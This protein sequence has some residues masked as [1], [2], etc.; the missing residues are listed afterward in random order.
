MRSFRLC[1]DPSRFLVLF[2]PL[3]QGHPASDG[4]DEDRGEE[5]PEVELETV[6]KGMLP[7][8]R[9]ARPA[10][11]DQEQGAVAGVDERVNRFRPHRRAARC[12]GRGELGRGNRQVG[13]DGG[14]DDGPSR[15]HS[16]RTSKARAAKTVFLSAS[17]LP[18]PENHLPPA[19]L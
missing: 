3:V 5:A 7:V 13:L 18:P 2:D 1:K 11:A 8:G 10:K 12:G 9:A 17:R 15:R 14:I 6:A 16:L 4:E 19:P